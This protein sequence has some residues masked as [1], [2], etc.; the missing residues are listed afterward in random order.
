MTADYYENSKKGIIGEV[1]GSDHPL[2]ALIAATTILSEE[3][4]IEITSSLEAK[5]KT[6]LPQ[7]SA[8]RL[9]VFLRGGLDAI[10]DEWLEKL[11]DEGLEQVDYK[12]PK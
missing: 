3:G 2:G 12:K 10:G 9:E 6:G 8:L 4:I 5:P 11:K 7:S 1:G